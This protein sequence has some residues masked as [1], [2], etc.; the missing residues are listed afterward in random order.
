MRFGGRALAL[1][2]LLVAT[3]AGAHEQLWVNAKQERVRHQRS[4]LTRVARKAL[5]SVVSIT[6]IQAPT[7][8]QVASS[9]AS[10]VE[11]QKG[12][13]A[14]FIIHPDG[15]ILTSQHVIENATE[16][17]ASLLVGD[18]K[19]EE[20]PVRVVGADRQSDF[21]LLKI[22]VP[23]KLPVLKLGS[24][25][26]V[27]VADWVVVIGN[28][29]GLG[30]S[31]TVGV[32]SY[33]GRQDVTP[34]GR[35]GFFDYLQTDASINPGSSGGPILDLHGDVV[36]IANA[37]NVSGQGI[38]FGIPIDMAKVVIPDLARHGAI[39]RGW[40]GV[41][42]EDGGDGVLISEVM[43]G[44]PA[45][46]AGLLVGDVIQ[47]VNRSRVER[48]LALRWRVAT[49]GAGRWVRLRIRRGGEPLSMRIRLAAEPSP[50]PENESMEGAAPARAQPH[51][52]RP[53]GVADP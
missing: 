5:G 48:A 34:S 6:T 4:E 23:R 36:A 14:G 42:V 32:V 1:A 18:G 50:D 37:V 21:A 52:T 51:P 10:S 30:H 22:D 27:D 20:Y 9:L 45:A 11:P 35:S 28:P 31:V 29:F 43:D 8:E 46:R 13:G 2:G 19:T 53:A 41:A 7:S 3:S 25:K 44:G 12:L 38:G 15:Y 24:A 47:G 16:I 26:A 17:R 39:N 33:K 40:L 49:S